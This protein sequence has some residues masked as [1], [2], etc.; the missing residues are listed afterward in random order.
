MSRLRQLLLTS[1]EDFMKEYRNACMNI[2]RYDTYLRR[3]GLN[4]QK[5]EKYRLLLDKWTE[6]EKQMNECLKMNLYATEKRI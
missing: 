5:I 4:V 6:R 3:E 2:S 1:P